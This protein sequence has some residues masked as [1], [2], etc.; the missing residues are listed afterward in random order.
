MWWHDD[1]ESLIPSI[2]AL[3]TLTAVEIGIGIGIGWVLFS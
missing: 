3:A 1:Q 2:L